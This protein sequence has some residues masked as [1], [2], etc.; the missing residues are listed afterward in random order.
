VYD[1]IDE[2]ERMELGMVVQKVA[3]ASCGAAISVPQDIDLLTCAYCGS[4]LMVRRGEGYI[5]SKLAEQV[6]TAVR[7]VGAEIG[8]RLD[9][10]QTRLQAE[11]NTAR[12]KC[13][14]CG[15]ADRLQR[16]SAIV[17]AEKARAERRGDLINPEGTKNSLAV[18]LTP[19]RPEQAEFNDPGQSA[20]LVG[21]GSVNWGI[22]LLVVAVI[23]A[24]L[25]LA[26]CSIPIGVAGLVLL[27][28]GLRKRKLQ[29][30][31]TSQQWQ[32]QLERYEAAS[33]YALSAYY[34]SRCDSVVVTGEDAAIPLNQWQAYLSS[35]P[36][37]PT[38]E[39]AA[40]REQDGYRL[41]RYQGIIDVLLNSSLYSRVYFD[42]DNELNKLHNPYRGIA[43]L[44]EP[45][46][47]EESG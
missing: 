30:E 11:S 19:R 9:S 47:Q 17:D 36:A 29:G 20:F 42:H 27:G 33:Q 43:F 34:C 6:T 40:Y 1:T 10:I 44:K 39:A 21:C 2:D 31:P 8:S 4:H 13:P 15:Q 5:A 24:L 35:V 37:T 41:T 26:I 12:L 28:F 46:L 32:T 3:C 14:S 16:V 25:S 23:C 38:A 7:E 22:V 45:A 18:R